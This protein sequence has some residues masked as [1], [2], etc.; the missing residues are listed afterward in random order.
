MKNDDVVEVQAF[1]KIIG[2]IVREDFFADDPYGWVYFDRDGRAVHGTADTYEHAA[3][4]ITVK[5]RS[6]LKVGTL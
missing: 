2:R 1:G 4:M 3:A 6:D 5:A